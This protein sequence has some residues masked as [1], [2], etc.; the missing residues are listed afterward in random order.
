MPTDQN[1][2]NAGM[3][4]GLISSRYA[5]PIIDVNM[6]TDD[7]FLT[8]KLRDKRDGTIFTIK[9]TEIKRELPKKE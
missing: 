6:A 4:M 5:E 1:I 9:V 3:V 2:V 8:L 7:R